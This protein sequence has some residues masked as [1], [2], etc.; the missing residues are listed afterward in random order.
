[1]SGPEKGDGDPE[2]P[3][4]GPS[5]SKDTST[6]VDEPAKA[7]NEENQQQ[8]QTE[9]YPISK[10]DTALLDMSFPSIMRLLFQR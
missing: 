6:K 7:S 5:K 3:E 8:K 4:T 1:M 2:K 10:T 9:R